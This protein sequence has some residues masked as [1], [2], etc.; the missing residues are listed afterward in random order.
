MPAREVARKVSM[1]APAPKV[2]PFAKKAAVVGDFKI[3]VA[4]KISQPY[5]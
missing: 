5:S 4:F 3:I 1:E 2:I